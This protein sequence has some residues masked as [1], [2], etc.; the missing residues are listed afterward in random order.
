MRKLLLTTAC[1][2]GLAAGQVANAIVMD[3]D[4]AFSGNSPTGQTPWLRATFT[5]SGNDVLLKMEAIGLTGGEFVGGVGN[6]LGWFFNVDPALTGSLTQAYDSDVGVGVYSYAFGTD[7]QKADGDG[8]YD[9]V[10]GFGNGVFSDN[11][12][13]TVKLSMASVDLDPAD[14][15]FLSVPAGGEGVY[16]TAAHIQNL[17][18]TSTPGGST[19]V[20][21][22]VPD[23]GTTA[24]L[25]GLGLVGVGFLARRKA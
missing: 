4:Y 1:L 11:D 13:L 6:G 12:S 9:F 7:S 15:D 21:S 16:R 2:A 23:G 24:A 14:F 18:G 8:K 19:W 5:D 22:S 3:L 10:F 20:G 25:L 17:T